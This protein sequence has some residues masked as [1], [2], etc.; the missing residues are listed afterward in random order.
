MYSNRPE[1]KILKNS[2]RIV[3][4]HGHIHIVKGYILRWITLLHEINISHQ[5]QMTRDAIVFSE[6]WSILL[7]S[8][9]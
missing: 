7:K 8:L 5:E 3:G 2:V 9:K 4:K 6:K 1:R